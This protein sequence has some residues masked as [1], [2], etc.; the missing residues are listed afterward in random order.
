MRRYGI[1]AGAAIT[2]ALLVGWIVSAPQAPP[3]FD[4][5]RA[6]WR[7]SDT[8]L[9]DRNGDPLYERRID[10]DGRRLAWTALDEISP[11]LER[12]VIASEDRRFH[13]HY[14]V[15][16]YAIAGALLRGATSGHPRGSSTITTATVHDSTPNTI[17]G[18]V[19]IVP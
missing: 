6:Q 16:L 15:D 8:L 14:G 9:L 12:A 2:L 1:A 19:G 13:D 3:S 7:P 17:V 10:V 18:M 11:A 4:E 5:V